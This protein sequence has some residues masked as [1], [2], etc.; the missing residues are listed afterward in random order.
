MKSADKKQPSK[1]LAKSFVKAME[2]YFPQGATIT[3]HKSAAKK[4]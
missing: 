2:K 3:P 4:K 1:K